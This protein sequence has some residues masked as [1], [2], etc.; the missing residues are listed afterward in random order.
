MSIL[1]RFRIQFRL[2]IGFG[3]IV[4]LL[5]GLSGYALH[6]GKDMLSVLANASRLQDNATLNQKA[7]KNIYQGRYQ[8]WT[9]LS[10][11][12]E[13]HYQKALEAFTK[14]Q[15]AY[16]KIIDHSES[17]ER[18]QQI[19][20]M[21]DALQSYVSQLGVIKNI[22]GQNANIKQGTNE[23][24]IKQIASVGDS[25]DNV[26]RQLSDGIEQKADQ[27]VAKGLD[28]TAY[29]N[30]LNLTMSLISLLLGLFL[31]AVIAR[32]IAGPIKDMTAA[33]N[34]MAKGDLDIEIPDTNDKDEIG[35][36]AKAMAIFKDG[37]VK[38]NRL[39]AEQMKHEEAL[40]ARGEK[41]ERLADDFDKHIVKVLGVVTNEAQD[42]EMTAQAM[43]ATAEE[44]SRQ[45][46]VVAAATEETSANVQTVASAAEELSKSIQEISLQVDKSQELSQITSKEAIETNE[47]IKTL[48]ESSAKI[49]NIIG[50]IND[51][52]SQTNLLALNATIE[53]ARAGEA[54]K[55]FAVV[56]SEVK[57]LANQTAKATEEIGAQIAAVQTS[58]DEAVSAIGSIVTRIGEITQVASA[59]AAAVEEQSAATNEIA[60]NVQQTA[61]GSREVASNLSGVTTAAAE[62]GSAATKVLSSAK[63]L[64]G[65]SDQLKSVVA[66]FLTAVKAG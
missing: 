19:H 55:G 27:T 4:L 28:D 7:L 45:A 64:T 43:S 50:L 36:M 23:A 12:D 20:Q 21:E 11:G 60:R 49:G 29:G 62:T 65:E 37:L 17:A 52:A 51:I 39:E 1:N 24:T 18:K 25:L 15:E 56:A 38:A 8:I 33:M 42:M 16:S 3:L 44:T 32:S 6:A 26:A 35:E 57:Q 54:G 9:Y 59:I 61:E 46:S 47:R 41:I 2:Y 53:A 30:K 66:D 13:T 48:A 14:A 34:E 31:A 40:A 58:T 10:T 22:G 5:L 63:A